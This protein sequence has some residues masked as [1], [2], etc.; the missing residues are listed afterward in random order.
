MIQ[1]VKGAQVSGS[2]EAPASKSF[3]QRALVAAMFAN[4]TSVLTKLGMCDDTESVM[5]AIQAL[6]AQVSQ[7]ENGITV[8]GGTKVNENKSIHIGESGLA[9]RL[10]APVASLFSHQVTIEGRG[11]ILTRPMT[12]VVEPLEALGV[13]VESNNGYL[14]LRITGAAQGKEITLDA[15]L[16]SQFLSGLLMALPL[17]KGDTTINV[18]KL[19]SKPYIDMTLVVLENFGIEIINDNYERFIIKGSQS[20]QATNYQ[21]EG[22]WSGA[23]VP[24]VMGA[25]GGDYIT[26]KGLNINSSQADRAI[27]EALVSAGARMDVT[28]EQI[29]VYSSDLDGYEFDATDCP[30]LFPA[31]AVL[32][33]HSSGTSRIKGT[34]R[35]T[36]KESDRA[37]VLKELMNEFSINCT[38][39]GDY[40]IIEGGSVVTPSTPVDSRGDHRIAMAAAAMS[41][42]CT[43]EVTITH[44]EAVDKSYPAFWN[45]LASVTK[46]L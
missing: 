44:S 23:S 38:L 5:G 35:L 15:S 3:S 30:D 46:S 4:G 29:T 14:P 24:L 43:S 36:H 7:D 34:S 12:L 8:V 40:M 13:K 37:T 18:T 17:A 25:I 6:G 1:K 21:I 16:S 11:T 9:T 19:S 31:L 22:D 33:A 45:D 10:F 20:Y 41:L 39:E 28:H 42:S 2:I 27:M 32:A 26:I